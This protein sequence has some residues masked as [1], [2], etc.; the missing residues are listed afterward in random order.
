MV[1]IFVYI[2]YLSRMVHL[3]QAW[4]KSVI[5]V[6]QEGEQQNNGSGWTGKKVGVF[7]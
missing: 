7:T 1:V 3:F 5:P 4:C 2:L 6:T